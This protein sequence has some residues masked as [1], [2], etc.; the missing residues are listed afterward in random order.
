MKFFRLLLGSWLIACLLATGA[1]AAWPEKPIRLIVPYPPG[2]LTDA[3]ARQVGRAAG[4]HA[5]GHFGP[6]HADRLH[7]ALN[8]PGQHALDRDCRRFFQAVV[9]A[10]EV[11]EAAAKAGMGFAFFHV[12]SRFLRRARAV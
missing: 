12:S 2:G 9:V 5:A 4:L 8:L 1:V 7:G 3:V 10:E 6:G 11:L